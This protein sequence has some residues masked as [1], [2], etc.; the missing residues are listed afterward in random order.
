MPPLPATDDNDNHTDPFSGNQ[1]KRCVGKSICIGSHVLGHVEIAK[2]GSWK[3]ISLT[4]VVI[5][6]VGKGRWKAAF[7]CNCKPFCEEMTSNKL[8]LIHNLTTRSDPTAPA[9]SATHA[10]TVSDSSPDGC[11]DNFVMTSLQFDEMEREALDRGS[12]THSPMQQSDCIKAISTAT[13]STA[14]A[15][16]LSKK[17]SLLSA[18]LPASLLN[19]RKTAASVKDKK[20]AKRATRFRVQLVVPK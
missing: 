13:A 1:K 15:S 20:K 19:K 17:Q 10:K 2:L 9:T 5:E 8:T 12:K 18:K 7:D 4:G 11:E 3:K 6:A 16:L 14:T